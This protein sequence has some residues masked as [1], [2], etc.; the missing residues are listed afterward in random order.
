MHDRE[1]SDHVIGDEWEF[2]PDD[3]GAG[4]MSAILMAIALVILISAFVWFVIRLDPLTDDFIG[5]DLPIP[6]ATPALEEQ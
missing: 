1:R 5:E 4:L 2:E 3:S 6:T